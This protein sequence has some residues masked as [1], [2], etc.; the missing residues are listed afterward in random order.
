MPINDWSVCY[1]LFQITQRPFKDV[2]SMFYTKGNLSITCVFGGPG[3]SPLDTGNLRCSQWWLVLMGKLLVIFPVSDH[4]T[5]DPQLITSTYS[6]LCMGP[7]A[8]N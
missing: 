6:L 2:G 5:E 3:I 1:Q 7:A 4:F 8:V